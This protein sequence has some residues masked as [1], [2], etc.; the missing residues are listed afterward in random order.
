[1]VFCL[2]ARSDLLKLCSV[3]K[4]ISIHSLFVIYGTILTMNLCLWWFR[5]WALWFC[6]YS[7]LVHLFRRGGITQQMLLKHNCS[8]TISGLIGDRQLFNYQFVLWRLD[9]FHCQRF[10]V[11]KS[12]KYSKTVCG[13][14]S[15]NTVLLFTT[16]NTC[17]QSKSTTININI[18]TLA[19]LSI[20][21]FRRTW[22]IRWI[23][24]KSKHEASWQ[25]KDFADPD[26]GTTI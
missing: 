15:A 17:V 9:F 1:M 22:L 12:H 7:N 23:D 11:E 10:P 13:S 21:F 24:A 20:D 16:I 5:H 18:I 3:S 14:L 26:T 4:K 6:V 25:W 8:M 19:C 2:R